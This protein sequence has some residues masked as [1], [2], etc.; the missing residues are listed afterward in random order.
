M[1]GMVPEY[2][3]E[4]SKAL[5]VNHSVR[6]GLTFT[7]IYLSTASRRPQRNVLHRVLNVNNNNNDIIERYNQ[8]TVS[9]NAVE[10]T[11]THRVSVALLRARH[12]TSQTG[13]ARH[14]QQPRRMIHRCGM[15]WCANSSS[16]AGK[17]V[18]PKVVALGRSKK[19]RRLDVSVPPSPDD[20]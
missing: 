14:W 2:P 18:L 3:S 20:N 13:I 8:T 5:D 19:P 9:V 17:E 6:L 12:V 15:M 11:A 1:P 4:R 7:E 16:I 10:L